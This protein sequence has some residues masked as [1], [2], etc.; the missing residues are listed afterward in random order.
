M[1]GLINVIVYIDDLLLH[2]KS[3]ADHKEQLEQLFNRLRSAGLKVNLSKC[4]FGA[5]NDS[6]L[7]Y[8][9]TPEGILPGLDKLKAVRDAKTT[10]TVQEIRQFMG[11]QFFL[12]PFQELCPNW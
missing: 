10:T 2:S 5:S 6:Y 3:H 9:L 7:G 4:E 1:K 11:L 8:R 12:I